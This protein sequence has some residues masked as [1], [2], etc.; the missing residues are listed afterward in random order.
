MSKPMIAA[1]ADT[2]FD[3]LARR[4]AT[5]A[6]ALATAQAET[7][8]LA[9]RDDEGRWRRPDLVWPLFAKG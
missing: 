6:A 9:G 4:L 1:E 8:A 3:D 5:R 7:Q 2:A